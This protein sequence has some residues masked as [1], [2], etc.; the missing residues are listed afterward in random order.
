M[1]RL[2]KMNSRHVRSLSV[3]NRILSARFGIPSLDSLLNGGIPLG[4][5]VLLESGETTETLF[6]KAYL[7]EGAVCKDQLLVYSES[8]KQSEIGKMKRIGNLSVRGTTSIRYETFSKSSSITQPYSI[9]IGSVNPDYEDYHYSIINCSSEDLYHHLWLK[10]KD[11]LKK[12]S[13]GSRVLIGDFLGLAWPHQSL[14]EI[15][16]FL[17]S[18]KT[19]LR[20]KNSVCLITVPLKS[21]SA[22]LKQMLWQA[23]DIVILSGTD[24]IS[25]EK[26]PKSMM[27]NEKK[28]LVVNNN[29]LPVLE[30]FN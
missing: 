29:G 14:S 30:S 6:T 12:S 11:D 10:I 17:R 16:E 4:S 24:F 7:G 9:D 15:F 18:V 5:L 20:S 25:I 27:L 2:L 21:L 23:S 3:P 28:Y 22:N 8:E 19:L 1:V 26:P 13:G